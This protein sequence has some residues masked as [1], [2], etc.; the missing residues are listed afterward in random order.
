MVEECVCEWA[1]ESIYLLH[2]T[3][4]MWSIQAFLLSIWASEFL[5]CRTIGTVSILAA[6]LEIDARVYTVVFCLTFCEWLLPKEQS[7][8]STNLSG[9]DCFDIQLRSICCSISSSSRGSWGVWNGICQRWSQVKAA[10]GLRRTCRTP[11]MFTSWCQVWHVNYLCARMV[12]ELAGVRDLSLFPRN[13][14]FQTDQTEGRM[15]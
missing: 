10:G 15:I 1:A 6:K 14:K 9:V 8:V 4:V 3:L 5:H 2:L 7:L 12:G 13:N 11:Q